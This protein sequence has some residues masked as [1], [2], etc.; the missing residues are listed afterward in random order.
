M[1]DLVL[2]KGEKIVKFAKIN[3]LQ[4]YLLYGNWLNMYM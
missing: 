3:S 4:N 1:V 2:A